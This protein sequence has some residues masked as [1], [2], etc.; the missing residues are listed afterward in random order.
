MVTMGDGGM[1]IGGAHVL[2]ACRRNLDITLLVLNN[3]NY[4]MTGGQCSTTTPMD[5]VVG[6]GFL[7]RLERP[8]DIYDLAC[9]GRG[10]LRGHLLHLP[11][12][13]G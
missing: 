10:A 13:P 12:R 6:S 4:G 9:G 5:A 2:A 8:T 1:G 7:N 3:F 11:E